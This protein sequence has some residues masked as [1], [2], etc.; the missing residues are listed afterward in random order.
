MDV[1]VV[2]LGG[3]RQ[4]WWRLVF[5]VSLRAGKKKKRGPLLFDRGPLL[6]ILPIVICYDV[7]TKFKFKSK[8][9][10]FCLRLF[11]SAVSVSRSGQ[12]IAE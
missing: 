7:A 1:A 3:F 4:V 2:V 8:V 10:I 11:C 9:K 5:V 6:V 12:A